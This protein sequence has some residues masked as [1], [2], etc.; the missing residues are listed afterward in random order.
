ML[1]MIS[2]KT[3]RW[4]FTIQKLEKGRVLN[5]QEPYRRVRFPCIQDN[6]SLLTPDS[7]VQRIFKGTHKIQLH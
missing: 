2:L 3:L 5:V 7:V 1:T 6:C 4:A